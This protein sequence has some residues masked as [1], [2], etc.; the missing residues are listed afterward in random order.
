MTPIDTAHA[1]MEAAPEDDTARLQFYE[2]FADGEL[3]LLLESEPTGDQVSPRTFDTGE[4]QFVLAFDTED[5]L[6]Q[7]AGGPAPYAAVSGRALSLMLTGQD[8]GVGLNLDVAPSSILIPPQALTWLTA[9]L[10][11]PPTQASATPKE[12]TAP[13]GLP[14]RLIQSLDTKL[15]TA[16]GLAKAA[17]L[18]GVTYTDGRRGHLLAVIGARPGS[19]A[20]LAQAVSEALVF[21]GLDAGELD[22]SFLADADPATQVLARTSLRFDL[23]EPPKPGLAPVAPGM[24]PDKPPNLR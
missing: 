6:A 18:T 5:R 1:A 17:F 14:E 22:V 9:T 8:I 24:D 12:F 3:F 23:P 21:S 13:M 10:D 15:A 4:G 7:F 16:Q 20:A 19:E 2:R 11:A